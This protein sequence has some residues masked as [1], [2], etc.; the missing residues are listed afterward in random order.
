MMILPPDFELNDVLEIRVPVVAAASKPVHLASRFLLVQINEVRALEGDEHPADGEH[1]H[2]DGM[3]LL[4][5]WCLV[6]IVDESGWE[7]SAVGNC[8]L[9]TDGSGPRPVVDVVV[10]QPDEDGRDG[11]VQP[12][13]HEE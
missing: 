8:E 7:P 2:D 9:E 12:R 5:R 6:G 3:G 4:V 11:W 10:G 1:S 13:S